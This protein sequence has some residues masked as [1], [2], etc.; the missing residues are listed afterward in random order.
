MSFNE[1]LRGV[2]LS[3]NGRPIRAGQSIADVRFSPHGNML[4][5]YALNKAM[6]CFPYS[7]FEG[8]DVHELTY[9]K[10]ETQYDNREL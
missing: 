5:F 7:F 10:L 1:S 3:L 2:I 4:L 8:Q 6:K 9:E